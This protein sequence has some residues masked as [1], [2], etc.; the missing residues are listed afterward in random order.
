ML[1]GALAHAS[2]PQTVRPLGGRAWLGVGHVP[3]G[4]IPHARGFGSHISSGSQFPYRGDHYPHRTG[5]VLG[6]NAAILLFFIVD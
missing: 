3:Y 6:E 2:R 1:R 4:Q 5:D